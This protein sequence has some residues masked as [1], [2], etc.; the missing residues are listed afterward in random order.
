MAHDLTKSYFYRPRGGVLVRLLISSPHQIEPGAVYLLSGV[1]KFTRAAVRRISQA[2]GSSKTEARRKVA[3]GAARLAP[4]THRAAPTQ[5]RFPSSD[6]H[7]YCT[8]ASAET[9]RR[10]RSLRDNHAS[11]RRRRTMTWRKNSISHTRQGTGTSS[12]VA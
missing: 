12:L 3:A 2:E 1:V 5:R 7:R 10:V 9:S 6:A 4:P 8:D 11:L